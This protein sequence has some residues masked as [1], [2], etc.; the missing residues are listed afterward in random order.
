MRV[1]HVNGT[2]GG[3]AILRGM[4]EVEGE[5]S[6]SVSG[7]ITESDLCFGKITKVECR[8]E[9][10]RKANRPARVGRIIVSQAGKCENSN[11]GH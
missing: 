4:K 3:K 2:R 6:T 9:W 10:K 5:P 8:E 1:R 11:H 7:G